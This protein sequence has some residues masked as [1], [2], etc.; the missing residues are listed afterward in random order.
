MDKYGQVVNVPERN[1]G[2]AYLNSSSNI[3]V[4]ASL[5]RLIEKGERFLFLKFMAKRFSRSRCYYVL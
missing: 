4:Q 2:V 1:V 5:Q 3:Q